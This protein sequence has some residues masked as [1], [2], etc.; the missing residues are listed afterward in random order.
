MNKITCILLIFLMNVVILTAQDGAY[1]TSFGDE[2]VVLTDLGG[3]QSGALGITQQINGKLLVTAYD[4]DGADNYTM[5]LLRYLSNGDLDPSF[6]DGGKVVIL[7]DYSLLTPHIQSNNILTA[8]RHNNV[9]EVKRY[10]S[11]G[12][13]DASFGD[14]GT[15]AQNIQGQ[16]THFQILDN[17]SFIMG[18]G[19]QSNETSSLLMLKKYLPDGGLDSLFGNNGIAVG[20]ISFVDNNPVF[21][22]FKVHDDGH[23][24]ILARRETNQAEQ[25]IIMKFLPDGSLDNSF[26]VNGASFYDFMSPLGGTVV[27]NF[28]IADDG[29]IIVAGS[30]G[31]CQSSISPFLK[32]FLPNGQ[33]DTTFGNSGS[34]SLPESLNHSNTFQ[35]SIQQNNRILVGWNL[36]WCYPEGHSFT[37]TRFFENGSIDSSF[38]LEENTIGIQPNASRSFILQDDGKIVTSARTN[39]PLINNN[40]TLYIGR[41][42]N[43]PLSITEYTIAEVVVF[44]NPSNGI[45]NLRSQL[46][47]NDTFTIR[48]VN[49]RI[50]TSG[51]CIGIDSQVNLS[52]F[53]AGIYFLKI[54]DSTIKLLKQ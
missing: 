47:L 22:D 45:F 30:I 10:T 29:K 53:P 1:D 12:E 3:V 42:L 16:N 11:S 4:W 19:F 52:S 51:V 23:I 33:I 24:Y 9:Y 48:D 6:G 35:V 13:L 26:G 41:H 8:G 25:M 50:L 21:S 46:P 7:S 5:Y 18:D 34:A 14:N 27:V 36:N 49:G 38:S 39:V 54:A 28:D 15:L 40:G 31:S 20:E 37:I 2:G 44:P 17:D 32:R 43:N